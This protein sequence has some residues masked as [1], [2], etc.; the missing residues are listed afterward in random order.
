[1]SQLEFRTKIRTL[2]QQVGLMVQQIDRLEA[3]I[4]ELNPGLVMP[5]VSSDIIS[6]EA[7]AA[8][9]SGAVASAKDYVP[10]QDGNNAVEGMDRN[11]PDGLTPILPGDAPAPASP[12]YSKKHMGFGRWV[13]MVDG[14]VNTR[15]I[16]D[17]GQNPQPGEETDKKPD[18]RWWTKDGADEM[19]EA[20]ASEDRMRAGEKAA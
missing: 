5:P 11:N 3:C 1:M 8:V 19:I 14:E 18:Q 2:Q 12:V 17:H 20:M 9:E 15:M 6:P 16:G 4:Q 7:L 10:P 13:I